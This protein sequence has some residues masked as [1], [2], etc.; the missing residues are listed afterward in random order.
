MD[1][2]ISIPH[3][4]FSMRIILKQYLRHPEVKSLAPDGTPCQ[5]DTTGLLRRAFIVAGEIVPVGKETD[6]HW[7]QGEDPSLIDFKVHEFRNM[8]SLVT[9]HPSDIARWKKKFG[10]REM[11]RKA[12]LAQPT[13]YA[14]L[15]EEPVR[16]RTLAIFKQAMDT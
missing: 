12:N 10:V 6:R 13:V 7:E 3:S 11:M 14:I 9:A 15:R 4:G 2:L 5:G 1:R 8:K 16:P